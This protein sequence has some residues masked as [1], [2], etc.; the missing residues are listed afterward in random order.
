MCVNPHTDNILVGEGSHKIRCIALHQQLESGGEATVTTIAGSG[1]RGFKD[2]P[3]LQ[4]QFN[5]ICG[6]AVCPVS[7]N[8]VVADANNH[9]IRLVTP[10]G[11][12]T[13]NE[14]HNQTF[15]LTQDRSRHLLE[16]TLKNQ[17]MALELL[18]RSSF[19]LVLLWTVLA[20]SS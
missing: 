2:G 1:E 17:K 4:A 20:S 10:Q 11:A 13:L 14:K 6:L 18:L 5:F 12:V 16:M 8:I 19:L 7:G 15:F 9:M 3:A